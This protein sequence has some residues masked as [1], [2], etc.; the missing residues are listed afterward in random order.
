MRK[1][2]L[3][4]GIIIENAAGIGTVTVTRREAPWGHF[5]SYRCFSEL[6]AIAID[7]SARQLLPDVD[8]GLLILCQRP[9]RYDFPNPT[10]PRP[11]LVF[12]CDT[13]TRWRSFFIRK[14]LKGEQK[15]LAGKWLDCGK[16]LS[17]RI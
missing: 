3:N 8:Q 9:R 4:K 1:N 13:K 5:Q 16:S 11:S 2:P 17:T 14:Q 7:I 10:F 15:F 12:D 6:R